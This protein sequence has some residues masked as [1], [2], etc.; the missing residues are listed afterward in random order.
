[1]TTATLYDNEILSQY[2][3]PAIPDYSDAPFLFSPNLTKPEYILTKTHC[4]GYCDHCHY[5]FA[6]HNLQ[7]FDLGCRRALIPR[8]CG[9]RMSFIKR[10]NIGKVVHLVRDLFDNIV[11]RMHLGVNLRKENQT[12]AHPGEEVLEEFSDTQDGLNAWC[13]Y[14]D[15]LFYVQDPESMPHEVLPRFVDSFPSLS[16]ETLSLLKSVPCHSEIFR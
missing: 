4:V 12:K 9:L 8:E 2:L 13:K 15:S 7:T 5:N 1:M 16:N 14:V 11:A 6:T 3:H 10:H